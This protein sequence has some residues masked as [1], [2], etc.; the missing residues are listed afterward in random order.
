MTG[1]EVSLTDQIGQ[2]LENLRHT[3]YVFDHALVIHLDTVLVSSFLLAAL[4]LIMYAVGQRLKLQPAGAQN[5]LEIGVEAVYKAAHAASPRYVHL[6]GPL[7]LTVFFSIFTFNLMDLL[8]TS[9]GH[10]FAHW[11][12]LGKNFKIVPTADL[13]VTLAFSVLVFFVIQVS[14][15]RAHGFLHYLYGWVAHPLG[16]SAFPANI[17]LRIIEEFA[18]ILSLA[19]RL[20]GNIFAGELVFVLLSVSPFYVRSVGVFIWALF[21]VLIVY[22]QAFVFM[23]LTVIGFS[24]ALDH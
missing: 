2:H 22:L 1:T 7:G 13:N 8:P 14:T 23:M 6:I 21:H 17:M 3:F 20:Y 9:L 10:H 12:H 18:R 4:S 16:L 24:L 5:I 19:M 15:V 11:A